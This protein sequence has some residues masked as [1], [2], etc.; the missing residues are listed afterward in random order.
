MR[1]PAP[2]SA[3]PYRGAPD[4]QIMADVLGDYRTL[5][6]SNEM[7]TAQQMAAAYGS[8]TDCDPM[9]DFA[10]VET[11]DRE[12]AYVRLRRSA[13]EDGTVDLN[14]FSPIRIADFPDT[15]LYRALVEAIEQ[16]MH[17]WVD[18]TVPA[19]FST[20]VLHPGPGK[21]ATGPSAALEHDGYE[22][23]TW[24]AHLARPHLDDVPD[25]TLPD[26]VEVRPV[27]P[28]QVRPIWQAFFEA[29]RGDWDFTEPTSERIDAQIADPYH[30]P[31]LWKV[32]WAGD[33]I[34]GQVKSYI[35]TAS[36]EVTG[37]RRGFTENIAT[38][39]AWR[40]QGIAGALLA[41]SLRELRDRGMTEAAMGVDTNNPGGA[42]HLYTSMGFEPRRY[43]AVYV[44]PV[45]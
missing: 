7:P 38:H 42:L 39:H 16:H 36:N 43:A 34:V 19:R 12:V 32:A 13:L 35:N 10:I 1:L 31:S 3:R 11:A 2:Y 15:D 30:D 27:S 5:D 41:M 37:T 21:Q 17:E 28:D 18:R 33:E 29:F 8:E 25:R 9:R 23:Q 4:H 14:W 20:Y 22:I 26:G 40:N 24:A 45:V 6:N 44:K